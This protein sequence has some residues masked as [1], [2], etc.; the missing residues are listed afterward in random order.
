[1]KLDLPVK[2]DAT[3]NTPPLRN[4]GIERIIVGPGLSHQQ[5][6]AVQALSASEHMRF[7]VV[8]SG[9]PYDPKA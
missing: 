6:N 4:V 7:D 9:I 1:V 3:K 2:L 8:K 5:I